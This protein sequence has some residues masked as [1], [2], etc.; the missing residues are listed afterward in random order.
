MS[1]MLL[2]LVLAPSLSFTGMAT[3]EDQ[4]S[5]QERHQYRECDNARLC[6]QVIYI[7][8][9]GQ[10]FANKTVRYNT[11]AWQPDFDFTDQRYGLVESVTVRDGRIFVSRQTPEETLEFS[12]EQQ[13]DIVFDAGFHPYIQHHFSRLQAG[14]TLAFDFLVTNRERPIRFQAKPVAINEEEMV[15][16]V[17]INNPLIAL[18]VDDIRLT[19]RVADQA[20]LTF[21]GLT[22]IRRDDGQ[23]NWNAEII[24]QY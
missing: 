6:E 7:D 10:T 9:R 2:A 13:D 20:L 22:N 18:F 3:T 5:Y 1:N 23:G 4:T 21:N 14:E 11:P 12:L 24:Y 16:Q 19:Y 15:I 8:E 17:R